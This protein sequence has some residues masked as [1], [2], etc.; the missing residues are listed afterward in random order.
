VSVTGDYSEVFGARSGTTT[1]TIGGGNDAITVSNTAVTATGGA[2]ANLA[3]LDITGDY[4]HVAYAPPGGMT[5]STIGGGNDTIAVTNATLTVAGAGGVNLTILSVTGENT[6]DPTSFAPGTVGQ[7]NDVVTLSN[8]HVTSDQG[9][10]L[11]MLAVDTGQGDDRVAV[12]DSSFGQF[13]GSFGDGDDEV[14]F[15]NN[16]FGSAQ[17][18]GGPGYDR[19]GAAGNTGALTSVNFE[20]E[21]I[22]P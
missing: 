16:T 17:L 15:E 2:A 7:G 6:F 19:L 13:F 14:T 1:S 12:L 10:P 11:A 18:D 3:F 9:A 20:E 4:S 21:T 8:V 22:T 5:A